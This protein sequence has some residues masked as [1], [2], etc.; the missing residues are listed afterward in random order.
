MRTYLATSLAPVPR[1]YIYGPDDK[2]ILSEE[3]EEHVAEVKIKGI[4][5]RTERF[6]GT[7]HVAHLRGGSERYW[8]AVK[9]VWL[10]RTA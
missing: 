6:E 5:V 7:Q 9:D 4:E 8:G 1:L 2:L 3:I 10:G